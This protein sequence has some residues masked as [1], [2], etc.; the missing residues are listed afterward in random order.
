MATVTHEITTTDT[1]NGGPYASGSFSPAVDDLIVVM[2]HFSGSTDTSQTCSASAN[3]VTTFTRVTSCLTNV[4][5]F[6]AAIF[7]ADA[8]ATGTSSMTVSVDT[9]ADAANGCDISVFTVSGLSAAGSSA[10]RQAATPQENFV[11][12]TIPSVTFA[13]ACLTGNPVLGIVGNKANP[14]NIDPP[15]GFTEAADTG[16][17]TPVCGIETVYTDS[18]FTGTTLTWGSAS[19]QEGGTLAIELDAGGGGG[20]TDATPTPAVVAAT[21]A[22]P[23]PA[24]TMR[25]VAVAVASVAAVGSPTVQTGARVSV[26]TVAA[27]AGVQGVTAQVDSTVMVDVVAVVAAVPAPTVE[28]TTPDATVTPAVVAAVAAVAAPTVSTGVTVAPDAVATAA[29]VDSPGFQTGSTVIATSVAATASVEP[30]T[31]STGSTLTATVVAAATSIPT[32]GQARTAPVEAVAV[33]AEVPAP[34]I[35]VPS[36]ATVEAVVVAVVADVDPSSV[37][38]TLPYVA[39]PEGTSRRFATNTYFGGTREGARR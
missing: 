23:A 2:V 9:P 3:G 30:L 16:H 22:V 24:L 38:I 12:D 34:T 5:L 26:S 20:G 7:V 1:T 25:E 13:S 4:G 29:V 19:S 18:G 8:L 10:V 33:V 36:H 21:A 6:C 15:S 11:D 14:A 27:L 28:T 39:P 32:P 17:A 31:A 35:P 37:R